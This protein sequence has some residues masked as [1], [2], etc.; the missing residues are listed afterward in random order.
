MLTGLGALIGFLIFLS[1]CFG[2]CSYLWATSDDLALYLY[3]SALFLN[4]HG[5][6]II[7]QDKHGLVN[8]GLFS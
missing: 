7:L 5:C 4:C 2:F 8:I 6:Y 1:G 3:S